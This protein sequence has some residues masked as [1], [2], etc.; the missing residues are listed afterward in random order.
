MRAEGFTAQSPAS[1][2]YNIF[3]IKNVIF[4]LGNV[5]IGWDPPRIAAYF[6]ADPN[7][8]ALVYEKTYVFERWCALDRGETT[9]EEI[10]SAACRELPP[11]LHG[12][13]RDMVMRWYEP[14]PVYAD[15]QAL[16]RGLKEAGKGIYLLSNTN[17]SYFRARPYIPAL[18][19]FDGTL[20]SMEEGLAKPDPAI[21]GRLYQRFSLTPSECYFIDDSA[22]NIAAAEKTGMAGFVYSGNMPELRAD[23]ERRGVQAPF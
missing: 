18:D 16:V 4:D 8:R 22:A 12:V 3:M 2:C 20:L 13:V 19:H 11:R 10:I 21:Y 17:A 9:E 1:L 5:L 15:T 23:L 6:A 7:D 14:M